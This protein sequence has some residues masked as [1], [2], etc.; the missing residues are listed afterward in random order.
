MSAV[1]NVQTTESNEISTKITSIA[2]KI[3]QRLL[4]LFSKA[5]VKF[6]TNIPTAETKL[7]ILHNVHIHFTKRHLASQEF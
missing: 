7:M 5:C 3:V 2:T 1:I 6:E 4:F